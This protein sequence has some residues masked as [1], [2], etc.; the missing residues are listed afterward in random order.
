MHLKEARSK[1]KLEQFAREHEKTHPVPLAK[2]PFSR[3][4]FCDGFAKEETKAGNI[5]EGFSRWLK[6][7][8]NS[9]AYL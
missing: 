2:P 1:N 8:S 6:R 7:Y 4:H 9:F 3:R 5:A